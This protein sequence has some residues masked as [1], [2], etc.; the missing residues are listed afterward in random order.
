[1]TALKIALASGNQGKLREFGALL[2]PLNATVLSQAELG[3]SEA[4][5]D[6]ATFIE[7]ALKKARHVSAASGLPA[8]AD[9]SG[10]VVPA[11][12]GAPG[13]FSARYAG[14][15]GDSAANNAKLLSALEGNSERAAYFYC[16]LVFL[17]TEDDPAPIVATAAWHGEIA[18]EPRGEGGFG[19]DPIFLPAGEQV[20]AAEMAADAKADVSHRGQATRA[21]LAELQHRL[22]AG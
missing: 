13:I 12:G 4:I 17:G 16:A 8:I 10:I 6:G 18:A 9:D 11:L 5:E 1:M 7:N 20:S 15:H 22:T 3:V 19:Y 14:T 21:L 2:A